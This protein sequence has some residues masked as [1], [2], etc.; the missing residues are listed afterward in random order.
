MWVI[1]CRIVMLVLLW[2]SK[3]GMWSETRSFSRIRPS[4][5]S[6]ITLVVVATTLVSDARSKTVSSVIASAAGVDGATADRLLIHDA[7]AAADEHDR[8]G[9][10]LVG[11]R[12]LD[13]RRNRV[14]PREVH[15][16]LP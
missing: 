12:L 14:Q 5:T 4:S 8:S 1:R 10:L 3:P 6:F 11:D 13:E 7:I 16:G 2:R 15:S 9:Q